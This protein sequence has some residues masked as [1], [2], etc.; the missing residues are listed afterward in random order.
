MNRVE[1]PRLARAFSCARGDA[2]AWSQARRLG[3][4]D[5]RWRRDGVKISIRA[6]PR[7]RTAA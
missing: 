1:T 5:S 7:S 2:D 6:R 3:S 4:H